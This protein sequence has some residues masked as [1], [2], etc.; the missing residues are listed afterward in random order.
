ML[1]RRAYPWYIPSP[2]RCDWAERAHKADQ[3]RLPHRGIVMGEM[4]VRLVAVGD[5]H[6]MAVVN[7]LH[8]A[9]DGAELWR[10]DDVLDRVDQQHLG[11]DLWKIWFG[12][13]VLDRLDCP[14]RII[15]VALGASRHV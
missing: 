11:L 13:V 10:V 3:I 15:G 7:L 5:Q 2:S 8:C 12:A 6:V 9:L 14:Q 1:K 4:P